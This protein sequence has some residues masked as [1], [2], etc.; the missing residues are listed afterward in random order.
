MFSRM[1][2]QMIFVKFTWVLVNDYYCSLLML[3]DMIRL[4]KVKEK[5]R[6]LAQNANGGVPVKKQSAGELRLHKGLCPKISDYTYYNFRL[7]MMTLCSLL[8]LN[9]TMLS[10]ILQL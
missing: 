4:F 9:L 10:E 6:E 5:Q 7:R 2:M 8:C 3:G 1:F